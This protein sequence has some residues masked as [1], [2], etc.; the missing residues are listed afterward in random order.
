MEFRAA[1]LEPDSKADRRLN[2]VI[3]T[4]MSNS[5]ALPHRVLPVYITGG[6]LSTKA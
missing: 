4:M 3:F 6:A 2:R 1:F 5:I